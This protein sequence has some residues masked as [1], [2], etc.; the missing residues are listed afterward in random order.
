MAG[1]STPYEV[2]RRQRDLMVAQFEEVRA[3]TSYAK[4]RVELDRATGKTGEK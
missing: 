1:L 4:A 3:R 2:I